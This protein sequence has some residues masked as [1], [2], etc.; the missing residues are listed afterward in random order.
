MVAIKKILFKM[1]GIKIYLR[2]LN[3]AFRFYYASGLL[4][5]NESY[6]FFYFDRQIIGEGDY[7]I[8][9]GANLGYFSGLFSDW[10]GKTGKVFC[11]EPVPIFFETLKWATE[12]KGNV[13]LHNYALGNEDGKQVKLAT[14]GRFGYIRTGLPHVLSSEEAEQEHEFVFNA[15]MRRGSTLFADLK[16]MDFIKCDIEGYESVVL[17]EMKELIEKFKPVIQVETAG[18]KRPVV[19]NFLKGIGYET[20]DVENGKLI[21]AENGRQPAGDLLMIHKQNSSLIKKMDKKYLSAAL[22]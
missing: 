1:L 8:D 19:E 14:P 22:Q 4:K 21:F 15:V 12:K 5:K 20:Y 6:K 16:R 3:R 13:V 11:V 7:V 2:L 17:P 9:I 10:V 18:D